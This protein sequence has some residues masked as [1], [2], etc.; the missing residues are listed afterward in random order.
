MK[1]AV[2][3]EATPLGAEMVT[4]LAAPRHQDPPGRPRPL[5]HVGRD[6][7]DIIK[8][9]ED[10]WIEMGA[11]LHFNTKVTGF[12]GKGGKLREVSTSQG[13]ITA[14]L[15]V[16]ATKKT[17][18]TAL[19]TAAGLKTGMSGGLIVDEQMAHLGPRRVRGG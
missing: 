19:A 18:N 10:S 2:V 16:V 13:S 7:P 3:D 8:P 5:G 12:V 11:E 4:A 1:T 15:A 14:D 6:R 17:P 9:V